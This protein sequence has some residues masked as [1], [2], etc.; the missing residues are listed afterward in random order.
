[1]ATLAWLSAGLLGALWADAV[2]VHVAPSDPAAAQAI[3]ASCSEALG[4]AQCVAADASTEAAAPM[5]ARV[6]LSEDALQAEIELA[7]D[8]G[9]GSEHIDRRVLTFAGTDPLA[10]RHR[11]IGLVIAGRVLERERIARAERERITRERALAEEQAREKAARPLVVEPSSIDLDLAGFAA[12]G[13]SRGPA[14]FGGMLRGSMRPWPSVPLAGLLSLRVAAR[15]D[16][17]SVLW[18]TLGAGVIGHIDLGVARPAP[19]FA[20]E[21]RVEALAQRIDV[22]VHD[23]ISGASESGYMVRYGCAAGI[24][25]SYRLGPTFALFA[26]GETSLLWKRFVLEVE[27]R[28]V[29]VEY[30]SGFAALAGVRASL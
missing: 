9:A 11:A 20:L 24:E 23:A 13:L 8:D 28:D 30:V 17:P 3:A 15:D 22:T 12:P 25:L 4:Q 14:R 16:E 19:G 29:N 6:A 7:D 21:L 10:E 2:V 26:G 5:Q 18:S 1:L 27:G